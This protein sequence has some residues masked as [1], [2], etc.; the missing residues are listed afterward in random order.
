M[1]HRIA[2]KALPP[3]G[4]CQA[5]DQNLLPQVGLRSLEK[6]EDAFRS[7]ERVTLESDQ[8][9]LRRFFSPTII[10]WLGEEVPKP[11]RTAGAPSF[12]E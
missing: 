10:V 12:P 2:A 7:T 8:V 5:E 11:T 6:L 9:W 1:L 4:S 3:R